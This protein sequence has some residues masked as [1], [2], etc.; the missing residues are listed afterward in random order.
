MWDTTST[1]DGPRALE[2]QATGAVGNAGAPAAWHTILDD[3]ACRR[4]GGHGHPADAQQRGTPAR[5]P[6]R[7]G[8]RSGGGR[9]GGQR[10]GQVVLL[11][12]RDGLGGL[13][14]RRPEVGA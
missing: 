1:N 10:R 14:W 12:G 4:A 9:F 3:A 5:R 11:Q 8:R 6:Q 2:L 13:G 7:Y